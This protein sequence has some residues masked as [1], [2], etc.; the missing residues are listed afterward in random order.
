[1]PAYAKDIYE[2]GMTYRGT[3]KD[4]VIIFPEIILMNLCGDLCGFMSPQESKNTWTIWK[5]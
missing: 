2:F 4:K 1:M 3:V 5:N